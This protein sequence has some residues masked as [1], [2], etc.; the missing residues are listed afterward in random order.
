MEYFYA[1]MTIF[2]YVKNLYYFLI[3]LI[4]NNFVVKDTL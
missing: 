4:F 2:L 3:K 1:I